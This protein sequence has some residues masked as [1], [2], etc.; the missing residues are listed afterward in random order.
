MISFEPGLLVRIEQMAGE[1]A[2]RPL[3][4]ASGF[5]TGCAYRV[6]GMHS[7]SETSECYLVLANDND[8]L[9]FISNRH[10]RAVGFGDIERPMRID[11]VA[12][13]PRSSVQARG[14][15]GRMQ[16]RAG[17]AAEGAGGRPKIVDITSQD[18][19]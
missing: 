16:A 6:L 2:P 1:R 14:L 13:T 5:R 15:P 3:P 10:L 7:A 11:V 8:E 12:D 19:L 4:L 18:N 17:G 9:W